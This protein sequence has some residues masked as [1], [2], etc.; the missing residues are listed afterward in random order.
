MEI[1]ET[2]VSSMVKAIKGTYK[3]T[4]HKGGYDKNGKGI[5]PVRDAGHLSI[6]RTLVLGAA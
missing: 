3:L 5:D 2:L 1:T 6:I 4:Y